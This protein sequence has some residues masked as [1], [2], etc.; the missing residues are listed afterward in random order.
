VSNALQQRPHAPLLV[1]QSWLA[2][3]KLGGLLA[4][5]TVVVL[6]LLM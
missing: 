4:V 3:M 2:V 5:G 6:L 1:H